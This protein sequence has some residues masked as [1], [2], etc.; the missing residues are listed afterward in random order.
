MLYRHITAKRIKEDVYRLRA[1]ETV[2]N[3]A[4]SWDYTC[5][6]ADNSATTEIDVINSYAGPG[7]L[8]HIAYRPA[9]GVRFADMPRPCEARKEIV[10]EAEAKSSELAAKR[11]GER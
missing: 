3:E 8:S 11:S 1:G 7:E 5:Q 9:P 2:I 10:S 6:L 4:V